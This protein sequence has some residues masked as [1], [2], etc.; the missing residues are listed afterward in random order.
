MASDGTYRM[1]TARV[2]PMVELARWLFLRYDLP[3]HEEAHAPMLH[4][5]AT[6]AAGGG[7]ELPVV[8]TPGG[9]IWTGARDV[10]NGVDALSPAGRKL[11][12]E[13]EA[14]RTANRAFVEELLT[15]LLTQVRRFVYHQVLPD[16]RALMPTVTFRAPTWERAFV[17][18]LYPVWR[19]LMARGL[20]FSPQALAD[21]PVKIEEALVLVED[22]LARRKTPFLGGAEPGTLDVVFSALAGPLVFPRNYGARLPAVEDLPDGLQRFI[23]A[24][25]ARPAGALILRT[26][27]AARFPRG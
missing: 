3:Y 13:T 5:V 18:G 20:D 16:K 10:L 2:S 22:E 17:G 14:E 26:Y 12:G 23:A 11:F 21:A 27:D 6:R 25:R 9:A 15:R 7:V 19:R 8:V 24:T 1:I 4:V